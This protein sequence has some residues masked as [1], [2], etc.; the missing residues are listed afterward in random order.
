MESPS[1]ES[2]L[3]KQNNQSPKSPKGVR[4]LA[5][6]I[7]SS[8]S[9]TQNKFS[10]F[11]FFSTTT[12]KQLS[13]SSFLSTKKNRSPSPSGSPAKQNIYH[14]QFLNHDLL[15][16]YSNTKTNSKQT[17]KNTSINLN[18][19]S[20]FTRKEKFNVSS[21]KKN[22][23]NTLQESNLNTFLNE[24]DEDLEKMIDYIISSTKRYKKENE[25]NINVSNFNEKSKCK[26]KKIGCSKYSCNC[27]KSGVKCG[28]FCSCNNC[29]NQ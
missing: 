23:M 24:K 20:S 11:K 18:S 12:H 22:L 21:I 16:T 10:A 6:N 14:L 1:I 28:K 15:H 13:T 5:F 19:N 27:L 3:F 4:H 29:L 26:C 9:K 25:E 2:S 7:T 8:N 17:T